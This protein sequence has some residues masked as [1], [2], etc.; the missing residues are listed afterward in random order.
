MHYYFHFSMKNF[1]ES[2]EYL[3]HQSHM[4]VENEAFG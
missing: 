4:E 3:H 2:E 1:Q